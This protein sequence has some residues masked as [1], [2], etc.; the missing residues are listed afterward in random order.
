L[1]L[2][3][4]VTRSSLLQRIRT[5]TQGFVVLLLDHFAGIHGPRNAVFLRLPTEAV[6]REIAA[7][8]KGVAG[9]AHAKCAEED[10]GLQQ[11]GEAVVLRDGVVAFTFMPPF[12][13][14]LRSGFHG[15]G[16]SRPCAHSFGTA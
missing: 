10:G 2:L 5:S 14:S 12:A 13:A 4:V 11:V 6:P 8:F 1:W 15:R 9:D 16:M 3:V 7:F